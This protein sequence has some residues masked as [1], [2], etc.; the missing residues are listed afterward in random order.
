VKNSQDF[1]NKIKD[2]VIPHGTLIGSL[3]VTNLFT[4][5]P[6]DETLEI[7]KSRLEEDTSL[8]DRTHKKKIVFI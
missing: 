7:L 4:T 6:V 2:R 3:D 8:K 1:I 5:T